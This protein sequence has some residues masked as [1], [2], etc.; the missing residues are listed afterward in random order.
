MS[1]VTL[2]EMHLTNFKGVHSFTCSFRHITNVF[3]DNATGKTTLIDAFLWLFFGKNSEGSSD[4]SVMRHD[5]TGNV[6][7]KIEAEVSAIIEVDGIEIKARKVMQQK[8][9]RR[10]GDLEESKTGNENLY[11][12]NDVP[13]KESEF[14]TK[15]MG[16][17]DE[18]LFRQITDPLYFNLMKWQDRRSVL[19]DMAGVVYHQEVFEQIV[20]S[21]NRTIFQP[22]I[23]AITSGK[24]LKEFKDEVSVKKT[25]AKKDS[26]EIPGRI[27]E[28]LRGKPEELDFEMLRSELKKAQDELE[29]VQNEV[30]SD[31]ARLASAN[32]DYNES[33]KRYNEQVNDRQKKVFSIKSEMQNIEFDVKQQAKNQGGQLAA[34]ITS[35]TGLI[36]NKKA[37]LER[38]QKSVTAFN[39]E[40]AAKS[41]KVEELREDYLKR[42]DE[43]IAPF[44][45]SNFCCPTCNRKLEADDISAKKEQL[46]NNFNTKKVGDLDAIQKNAGAIKAEIINLQARIENGSATIA[47]LEKELTS[48]ENRKQILL[49]DQAKAESV[50]TIIGRLLTQH[51]QYLSL[52]ADLNATEA[53]VIPEP[54]KNEALRDET[55]HAKRQVLNNRISELNKSLAIEEQIQ[56]ADARI[57]ELSEQQRALAEELVSLEGSEHAILLFTKAKVEAVNDRISR[58]FKYVKFK[59]IELQENGGEKECCETMIPGDSGLVPFADANNAAKINAGIDIINALCQHYGIYAPIFIDNRESVTKLIDSES[60]IVNLIVSENDKKL[61]VA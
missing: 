53:L 16:I 18:S 15:V 13:K 48:L 42:D 37:D 9:T 10:R 1:K 47:E 55:L 27:D 24:S 4:F 38:Y 30:N 44:D 32:K 20:N 57:E 43:E 50:E 11:Y 33:L 61:R 14:R 12:W 35:I 52:R 45:E 40:V 26:Q 46:T 54:E 29:Q 58:K 6:I 3:G 25:K 17:I 21:T 31:T 51:D 36:T 23:D 28:V 59:M 2:K 19:M 39:E 22:L 5:E 60:Q 34:E 7:K 56:K 49:E 8:W 41:I